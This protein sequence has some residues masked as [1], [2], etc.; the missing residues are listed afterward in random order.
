MSKRV[1]VEIDGERIRGLWM[2]YRRD[3]T[4]VY[5]ARLRANGKLMRRSLAARSPETARAELAILRAAIPR[6]GSANLPTRM[7]V[8][9]EVLARLLVVPEREGFVYIVSDGNHA[10]IGHTSSPSSRLSTLRNGNPHELELLAMF[11]GGERLLHEVFASS[12][13]RGE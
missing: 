13:R 3:G 12:R 8:S 1:P 5:E 11:P 10:K 6:R 7:G 4:R 2:R 9:V